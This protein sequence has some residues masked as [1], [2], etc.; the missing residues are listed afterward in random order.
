MPQC[1]CVISLVLG[2]GDLVMVPMGCSVWT[3]LVHCSSTPASR[4]SHECVQDIP[5]SLK[6]DEHL[7]GKPA[8]EATCMYFIG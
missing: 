1:G 4:G 2:G 7:I 3:Y 5:P 8:H 6:S